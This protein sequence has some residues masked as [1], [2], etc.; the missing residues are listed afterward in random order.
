M[1]AAEIDIFQITRCACARM[2]NMPNGSR[3]IYIYILDNMAHIIPSDQWQSKV[4]K[5][6]KQIDKCKREYGRMEYSVIWH[7]EQRF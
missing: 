5:I 3:N 4:P 2:W 7:V 1:L 6:W